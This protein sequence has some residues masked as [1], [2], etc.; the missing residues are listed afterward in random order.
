[1]E[2][3][4]AFTYKRS[5]NG[6]W[7]TGSL[8][9]NDVHEASRKAASALTEAFPEHVKGKM[10]RASNPQ[11]NTNFLPIKDP[12]GDGYLTPKMALEREQARHGSRVATR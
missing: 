11:F 12:D 5:R 3:I 1:M 6:S 2:Q 10:F 7:T 9:A 8:W 4:Y